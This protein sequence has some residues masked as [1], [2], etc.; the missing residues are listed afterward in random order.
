[1]VWLSLGA[2][3]QHQS[4]MELG[5]SLQA[6]QQY[7]LAVYHYNKAA[8]A[9]HP[10]VDAVL[11]MHIGLC[12]F[13]SGYMSTAARFFDLAYYNTTNDSIQTEALLWKIKTLIA[14]Q[15]SGMALGELL[16]LDVPSHESQKVRYYFYKGV[17][18]FE[19]GQYEVSEWSFLAIA[20]DSAAIRAHF[21]QPKKFQRPNAR[22]A[23]VM[24]AL[25]PGSGQLYAGEKGEAVNSVLINSVFVFYS[26]RI[27]QLYSPLD[28]F[29]AVL[30]WFQRYYMGGYNRASVLARERMYANRQVYLREIMREIATQN[31]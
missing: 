8:F 22:L 31:P 27:A 16:Q 25:L 19:L 9:I 12:H 7:S 11:S 21:A 26:I 3:G 17:C 23:M 29:I 15:R 2:F 13:E 20:K 28:A 6:K 10:Q 24:S 5:R 18:Q 14:E 1:M 4:D 30:P